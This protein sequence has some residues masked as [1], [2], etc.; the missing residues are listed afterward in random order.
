MKAA[1]DH[2]D[3]TLKESVVSTE[4]VQKTINKLDNENAVSVILAMVVGGFLIVFGFLPQG[5]VIG[6]PTGGCIIF[7]CLAA[8]AYRYESSVTIMK[9]SCA[10]CDKAM[11]YE[12]FGVM[13]YFVCRDCKIYARGRDRSKNNA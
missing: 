2:P 9:I 8:T 5:D 12:R 1:E 7:V 11:K 6:I 10:C 3:E 4:H 13:D